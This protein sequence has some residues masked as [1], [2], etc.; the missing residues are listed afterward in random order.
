[1]TTAF[2]CINILKNLKFVAPCGA[3]T[4]SFV[5]DPDDW[6]NTKKL[7]FQEGDDSAQDC[8]DHCVDEYPSSE[9]IVW[10]LGNCGCI[11]KPVPYTCGGFQGSLKRFEYYGASPLSCIPG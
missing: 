3:H 9:A 10:T 4:E 1:M 5:Y 7:T 11:L 6:C 2:L 8:W